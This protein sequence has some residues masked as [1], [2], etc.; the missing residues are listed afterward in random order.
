MPKLCNN[1]YNDY[2]KEE[3][4]Y[5]YPYYFN[6]HDLDYLMP[7][8]L[9]HIHKEQ[10]S[11]GEIGRVL[12]IK[13]LGDDIPSWVKEYISLALNPEVKVTIYNFRYEP[14]YEIYP[15]MEEDQEGDVIINIPIDED[16]VKECFITRG[17]YFCEADVK[18]TEEEES[19]L[20]DGEGI[21]DIQDEKVLCAFPMIRPYEYII[22]I[23]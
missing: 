23:V 20:S 7:D 3:F 16:I 8:R 14:I 2:Y 17:L 22:E 13:V 10:I 21:E 15:A 4:D 18:I 12:E 11:L 1:L 6:Q 9:S 19:P 5:Y